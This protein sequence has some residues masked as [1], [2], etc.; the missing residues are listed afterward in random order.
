M[1]VI[2]RHCKTL[3][4]AAKPLPLIVRKP[5]LL[6]L[7]ILRPARARIFL[8]TCLLIYLV[9]ANHLS[10]AIV[11]AWHPLDQNSLKTGV[12]E[13]LNSPILR[14]QQDLRE[15]R[16]WQLL[17]F[18][19]ML[20]LS[21]AS[22]KLILDL[23]RSIKTGKQMSA[24]LPQ[25]SD[26]ARETN[27]L[28]YETSTVTAEDL[29]LDSSQLDPSVEKGKGTPAKSL[30]E[31]AKTRAVPKAEEKARFVGLKQRYRIDKALA[32]GGAGVVYQAVDTVLG[33]K[34][35]LKE[36]LEDLACDE[37]QAERFKSE[38]RALALLNHTHIL[39]IYDLL[40]ENGRFWLVMELLT[41]GTLGDKIGSMGT[42]DASRIIEIVRGIA[43]GLEFAHKQGFVHR[44]I[45]P[46]NILFADDGSFRL[47][48]FGIAKHQATG[49][50]T[51]HGLI[52]GSPG[53]MSP[54]QAAGE[55]VDA[56]SDIYSLGITMY[57]MLTAELPF[58]GDTSC[59]MAQHITR[60]APAPSIINTSISKELDA[61]VLKML[62]KKPEERYQ[63]AADL[64]EAL[65]DLN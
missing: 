38:A 37:E 7:W 1:N 11:D 24:E 27:P 49:I 39:P 58:Q 45:K 28:L 25:Q 41:A 4:T 40:E 35:A 30:L 57:Q 5:T 53:Y 10:Q 16:Y 9:L 55:A 26:E 62:A 21:I 56:R 6:K 22:I 3:I 50:N 61:V 65:N 34:V 63:T 12:M 60:P 59:V 8:F 51:S 13:L 14:K 46:A 31:V 48:D 29:K 44:D 23:P 43:S 47:T 52:L 17:I 18:F 33:R 2:T 20:G 54:E 15:V 32:S 36:L 64:I 42:L 19:W